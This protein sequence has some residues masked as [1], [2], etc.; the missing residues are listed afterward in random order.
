MQ[1]IKFIKIS[2][3]QLRIL[4]LV[5]LNWLQLR[6][7]NSRNKSKMNAQGLYT[8]AETL[9]SNTTAIQQQQQQQPNTVTT[10][11]ARRSLSFTHL[12][13]PQ[14]LMEILGGGEGPPAASSNSFENLLL[15]IDGNDFNNE[16]LNFV[17][18][19]STV[20]NGDDDD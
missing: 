6:S 17:R 4:K 20:E 5:L 8:P 2:L 16:L 9:Q 3:P 7:G 12:L 13:S 19:P 11:T 18:T 1:A 15:S 10:I 14:E